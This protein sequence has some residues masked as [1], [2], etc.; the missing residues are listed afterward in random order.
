MAVNINDGRRRCSLMRGN[1]DYCPTRH[2]DLQ[3]T[4]TQPRRRPKRCQWTQPTQFN[5][6]IPWDIVTKKIYQSIHSKSQ[7]VLIWWTL[8]THM[9]TFCESDPLPDPCC[10]SITNLTINLLRGET[11]LS[12][13]VDITPFW[14]P[15]NLKLVLR[16]IWLV[17][18]KLYRKSLYQ[19]VPLV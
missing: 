18:N 8:I 11:K 7:Y 19:C 10:I 17:F 13:H 4:S 12:T 3:F 14:E 9:R 16:E 2:T 1:I 5:T 15:F 6:T